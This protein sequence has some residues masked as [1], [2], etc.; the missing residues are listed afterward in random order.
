M[1]YK[2]GEILSSREFY[3]MVDVIDAI[4]KKNEI[5]TL[6]FSEVNSIDAVT[7]PNLLFLGKYIE[8]K[9]SNIP[10]IRLG[11][12]LYSGY[13]KNYLFN[14][15]FYRLSKR[16][17]YYE[18]DDEKYSGF[19]GKNMNGLNTT[20]FF[21]YKSGL[22]EAQRKLFDNIYPF[23]KKY[24]KKFTINNNETKSDEAFNAL[25]FDNNTVAMFMSQMIDNSFRRGKSDAIITVQINYKKQRVYLSVADSGM[26][27]LKAQVT[28]MNNNGDF[29]SKE[30]EGDPGYNIIGRLPCNEVE[31]VLVGIYK[32]KDSQTYG[33]YNIIKM[34]MELKGVIRIHSNNVQYILTER[35]KDYFLDGQLSTVLQKSKGY[36][37]RETRTFKGAHIEIEL[38][39]DTMK[40]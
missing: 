10:Y 17:Y 35:L 25:A 33:L 24:F 6:D 22:E 9:T 7:I 2:V 38:P 14:I 39:F 34:V 8:D 32:R 19:M 5:F 1:E 40:I 18:N 37:I 31:A 26:G 36:N 12:D 23:I 13:L 16:Y 27:F 30:D 28:N 4:L 3:N 15:G 20:E 29:I 21:S 11:D